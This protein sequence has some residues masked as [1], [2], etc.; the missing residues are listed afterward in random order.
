MMLFSTGKNLLLT[1]PYANKDDFPLHRPTR[2]CRSSF[3]KTLEIIR[4]VRFSLQ[5]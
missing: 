1:W 5:L 4:K 2:L 3:G